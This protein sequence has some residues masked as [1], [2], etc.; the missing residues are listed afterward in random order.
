MPD[1]RGDIRR[2]IFTKVRDNTVDI[3]QDA[4]NIKKI[5]TEFSKRYKGFDR[6]EKLNIELTVPIQLPPNGMKGDCR[7]VVLE[8]QRALNELG[9][10]SRI[11]HAVGSWLDSASNIVS[12]HC[13]VVFSAIPIATWFDCIPV[14]QR[15]IRDEVQSKLFQ[16]CVF[17]R[18]DNQTFGEPL[19]LLG[20]QIDDFPSMDEFG[21]IDAAC[22][23]M[24]A[25]YEEHLVQTVIKQ[26]IVGDRNTQTFSGEDTFFASG[27]GAMAAK[28]DIT[29]NQGVDSLEH[30]KALVEIEKLRRELTELRFYNQTNITHTADQS[31]EYER[32]SEDY[33]KKI[34]S[35][36]NKRAEEMIRSGEFEFS[37][38]ALKELGDV[39]YKI[40]EFDVAK[41]HYR[42]AYKKFITQRDFE[43]QGRSL[44]DLGNV[45]RGT[46]DFDEA[47]K[48][49]VEAVKLGEMYN[50][51]LTLA[52]SLGNLGIISE[53]KEA[54]EYLDKAES[55]FMSEGDWDGYT[56]QIHN[57]IVMRLLEDSNEK[58][59][60]D[61][62]KSK[63][64]MFDEIGE[65]KAK[66][67][68][69]FCL[70]ILERRSGG[71]LEE[72]F[73]WASHAIYKDLEE[74]FYV[75]GC[76]EML[77]RLYVRQNKI[78]G[79]RKICLDLREVYKKVGHLRKEAIILTRLGR[80][81]RQRGDLKE[82]EQMHLKALAL[83]KQLGNSKWTSYHLTLLALVAESRD[84]FDEA[85]RLY[86]ES[87]ELE[88][89]IGNRSCEGYCL[90][91]LGMIWGNRGDLEKAEEMCL[92]GLSIFSEICDTEREAFSMSAL[93][94]IAFK[95]KDFDQALIWYQESLDR[96]REIGNQESVA[97][98]CKQLGMIQ[99]MRG[100]TDEA[101]ILH[102]E[103]LTI[104]REIGNHK[105]EWEVLNNHGLHQQGL[106]IS[107]E[108]GW[109]LA[110]AVSIYNLG[111]T[112][113]KR[114]N[115]AEAEQLYRESLVINREIGYR[116]G[117]AEALDRLGN[118][119][120]TQK[121]FDE[122]E[123]LYR[124]TLEIY[125]EV[126]N[127]REQATSLNNL[128]KVL[129]ENGEENAAN[130]LFLEADQI[131]NQLEISLDQEE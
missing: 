40:G 80:L 5:L 59:F 127:L 128:G 43:G 77:Y 31:D 54:S 51:N 82:S 46:G 55:I 32:S 45:A 110:E 100:N 72:E 117:E 107:R 36:A 23:T 42:S 26:E 121:N 66:A 61:K 47:R 4:I 68:L 104:Y 109:R 56:R 123:Q 106:A 116:Q 115:L 52:V 95:R 14:L 87:L 86:H 103:S 60:R 17:L 114:E 79:K 53:G 15:L 6:N 88:I 131:Y 101:A 12:D 74:H 63:I 24:M 125:S 73:I 113:E 11:Y 64:K 85:E 112:E 39:A 91:R 10:G 96:K 7:A 33:Q 83:D 9:G 19:N 119:A 120:R 89:Q 111:N 22:L 67:T 124:E 16:Q 50:H 71:I 92:Q 38:W 37:A 99:S 105:A 69:L 102:Q 25:E 84:D 118:I 65:K 49:F 129:Q 76:L 70:A 98:L 44:N 90:Y 20:T 1:F 3:M 97:Y 2:A 130:K 48:K 28:G 126:G 18:I 27:D 13:V 30:A 34:A 29:I 57:R 21:S 81:A 58:E 93:G 35:E 94:D 8:I 122:A 75:A 62:I 78:D 108:I 41:G